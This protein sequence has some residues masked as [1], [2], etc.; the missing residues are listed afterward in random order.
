[1]SGEVLTAADPE[2]SFC[3]RV[4][5]SFGR[6]WVHDDDGDYWLQDDHQDWDPESWT[7]VAGNYGPVTVVEWGDP[8]DRVIGHAEGA[9][10]IL[11]QKRLGHDDGLCKGSMMWVG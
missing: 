8:C 9:G 4:R 3:T 6:A 5:D 10:P 11:C 7:R 2:P 1:M